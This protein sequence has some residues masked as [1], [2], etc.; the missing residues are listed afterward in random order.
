MTIQ[1]VYA[2]IQ[3]G[4]YSPVYLFCPGKS[5]RARDASFEPILAE[6]CIEAV[7]SAIVD[8]EN[9][10]FAYAAFYADETPAGSI[11]QEAQTFPFL[12][13]RRVVF[14]RNAE[15]YNSESAAGAMLGY[16]AAPNESTIML[17]LAHKVDKRTKF[18]KACQ[19][20]GAIVECPALTEPEVT[21]W[22][23]QEVAKHQKM[24]DGNAARALID[25]TG[26]HLSD[27]QNALSLVMHYVGQDTERVGISDVEAACADVAEEE[28]WALTDA[29]ATSQSGA[30]LTSLRSLSDLGK[31]P[32]E[33]IGTINWLLKSA[34]AVAVAEGEPN[35]SRFVARKVAPLAQKLG[36]VKLR[37]AFA[38]CTDTQFMM[39]STGVDSALAL[40]LLVVKLSAPIPRRRSA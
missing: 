35:I 23:N 22:I 33:M 24:I 15:K 38:L 31:H 17:L 1:D 9:R 12:T 25:R 30:A 16:L 29:I 19:K 3:Q 37:A 8:Q 2:S 28:I 14:V 6:Q 20:A 18:Y 11:V 40:E 7:T 34:Y 36:L 26:I 39:R 5:P 21:S 13:D 10:D 4:T 32:D 27:V